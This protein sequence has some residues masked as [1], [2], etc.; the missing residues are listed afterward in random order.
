MRFPTMWYVLPAKAQI[1]YLC[2]LID[3]PIQINTI[4]MEL[5]ITYFKGHRFE[6][7]DYDV[8]KS[9]KI[10]LTSAKSI[11]PDEMQHYAAFHL[12]L[13]CFGVS[14]PQSV[15]RNQHVVCGTIGLINPGGAPI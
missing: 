2:I 9:V 1:K 6:F 8:F 5:S 12:G 10:V 4:R 11:D 13:Y 14:G 3:F 15:K 7:P